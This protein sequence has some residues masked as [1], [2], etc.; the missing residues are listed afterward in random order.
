MFI[1]SDFPYMVHGTKELMP[2]HVI[3]FLSSSI[4]NIVQNGDGKN[5]GEFGESGNLPK[6]YPP[7]V[8]S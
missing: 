7:K 4:Y 3:S 5:F 8:I 2:A 1:S 6:Y